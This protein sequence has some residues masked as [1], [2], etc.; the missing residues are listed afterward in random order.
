MSLENFWLLQGVSP[1]LGRWGAS[2]QTD[3]H[4]LP[5][6]WQDHSEHAHVV[7]GTRHGHDSPRQKVQQVK[8]S[9]RMMNP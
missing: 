6:H 2:G 7:T 3:L 5:G 1:E 9:S 8:G 4:P